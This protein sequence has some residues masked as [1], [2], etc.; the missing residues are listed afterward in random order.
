MEADILNI[1]ISKTKQSRISDVNFDE[2]K[3]GQIKADHMLVAEYANGTWNKVEIKPYGNLELSPACIALH[4]GQSIFEGMKAFKRSNGDIAMFRPEDNMRRLQKSAERMMMPPV[5]EEVFMEGLKT[6]IDLDR[7]WVPDGDDKSLYIRPYQFGNEPNIGVHASETS[8]FVIFTCPTG[9]YYSKDVNVYLEDYYIRAARG[10]AG[11]AKAAGNYAPT[12]LPAEEVKAKG[13]DQILWSQV[14]DEK[15]Y[16]QEIGTMN[17]FVQIDDTLITPELDGTILEG[18]TRDSILTI[19][20]DEGMKVEERMLSADELFQ[21]AKEGRVK[22]AF[23]SGTA[24]VVTNI[25]GIG[26]NDE[27]IELPAVADRELC[28]F[29]KQRLIDIRKGEVEDKFGWMVKV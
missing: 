6:L 8:L 19:A 26:R 4:Y 23:G 10:G 24:A 22:D 3:F 15:R 17:F 11:F 1:S 14:V 12:L 28:H 7:G 27:K 21:A 29:F 9:K 5:T 20:R 2:L 18:I 13:F 25:A 16:V